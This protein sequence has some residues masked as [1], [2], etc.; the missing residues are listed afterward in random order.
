MGGDKP[1]WGIVGVSLRSGSAADALVPQ[2]LLYCVLERDGE[3]VSSRVVGALCAALHAPSQ[4]EDVARAIA[5]PGVE[6]VTSTV[7]EK[8]YCI[9][10][11][12]G[13]ID[14]ADPGVQHD[15]GHPDAPVTTLGVL[16]AGLRR[17]PRSAPVTVLCCDTIVSNGD[18]VRKL[19]LQYAHLVDAAAERRIAERVAFPNSMVDRIVPAAT[20]ESLAWAEEHLGMRDEA[21]IVCEPFTQWVV[22]D[23]FAGARPRWERAG[24][25]LVSD[26]RPYQA[27]KLR[28]L[29]GTHSAIA[30]LGQLRDLET[31]SDAMADALVGPFAR[32]VMTHDLRSSLAAPAGYDVLGYCEQLLLRFE[33]PSLAHRTQQ[34]AMDGTQKVPVRWLPA[35]RESSSAG[36]ELP[37]LERVLAAWLH[38]LDT[39]RSD[40]GTALV[41]SD[42][43]A[44]T[45]AAR[46]RSA[47][48][49]A[50]A[51]GAAFDHASVF[52][53]EAW[54][55]TLLA[56]IAGHLGVLRQG[57]ASALLSRS[58]RG[59]HAQRKP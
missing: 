54:P 33:N 45:L 40:N 25:L 16:F 30:Y 19:V 31:V 27:M 15:V 13:D 18:T 42:P 28:L 8:G 55:E 44:A 22:E 21:A 7:T 3:R 12:T 32:R 24:A 51:V 53:N 29:N 50:Q 41:I 48:N 46:M 38:Y 35:L 1:R 10:P 14:V 2:D 23:R 5:D 36:V 20:P 11:A 34:I 26:V 43:G 6:V 47:G 4:R 57:G 37:C 56:R 49:E 17:R 52:G 58:D 59:R 9:S 39:E